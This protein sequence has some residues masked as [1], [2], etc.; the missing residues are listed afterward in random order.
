MRIGI[1]IGSVQPTGLEK[2]EEMVETPYGTTS[3]PV[4]LMG[5]GYIQ[6]LMIARHSI[7]ARIPPHKVNHRA[8]VW[9]LRKMVSECMISICSTGALRSNIPVP[10][11]AVPADYI[12][13]AQDHTFIEDEI[14][15][16]TPR[17]DEGLREAIY[18]SARRVDLPASNG[19]VYIQTKGPR[20]ET[21]AEIRVIS[22]W[23]DYVGMNLGSEATLANELNIPVA[24]LIT[25]DNYANGISDEELDYRSILGEARSRW[26]TV[27]SV[28]EAL[29]PDLSHR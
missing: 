5:S 15:H 20:L 13:L 9:A 26:E 16:I 29:P 22:G 28:L 19:G 12:D 6:F 24:G 1:L 7:P 11:L 8:N 27:R 14:K 25:V 21:K 3:S 17:L 2:K 10:S 23:G 4:Y 18:H